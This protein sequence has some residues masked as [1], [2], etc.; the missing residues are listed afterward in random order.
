MDSV[1][2]RVDKVPNKGPT[3]IVA[4][5][6]MLSIS[7]VL[8]ISRLTW[9]YM[10][11][12]KFN[13]S[14]LMVGSS[15]VFCIVMTIVG[16]E[17]TNWG[18][19]RHAKDIRRSGGNPQVAM[20]VRTRPPSNYTILTNIPLAN[21]E[22]Q[23]QYFYLFQIFYKVVICFN[24]LSFLFLYL[25][26]FPTR[27]FRITCLLT[28]FLI[29]SG[30]FSFTIA[31][32]FQ[33]TPVHKW[34]NKKHVPGHCIN[35]ASFRWSW[36]AFNT[37]SDLWVCLM[38]LPVI[39]KLQMDRAKKIGVAIV[40]ATGLFVCCTSI[41]RMRALTVSVSLASANDQSW[42]AFTTFV[43]S[44]V[45]ANTGLIC[46]CLPFLKRPIAELFPSLFSRHGGQSSVKT[47]GRSTGNMYGMGTLKSENGE[48]DNR[49]DVGGGKVITLA[50][51]ATA[52]GG[53]RRARRESQEAIAN[54]N[55]FITMRTDISL[56]SQDAGSLSDGDDEG[57]RKKQRV[58]STL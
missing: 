52:D 1:E 4:S 3:F 54:A 2:A 58:Q 36:A 6:S 55:G 26:L 51:A 37:I 38:P 11:T 43:W 32:I 56:T 53:G 42:A 13:L 50:S 15:L 27:W 10:R 41:L 14:E 21:N 18:F 45:E 16:C 20:I 28:L 22:P 19:G 34:W 7:A 46:A 44:D 30:S 48:F 49:V 5:V 29:L 17:A 23:T 47:R 12:R 24:K 8:V 35:N 39:A 9:A 33:C 40:F 57:R 25:R 31:T